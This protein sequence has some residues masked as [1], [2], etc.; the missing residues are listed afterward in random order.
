MR[1]ARWMSSAS[2]GLLEP[3]TSGLKILIHDIET[4]PEANWTWQRYK[5]NTLGNLRPDYM[6]SNVYGWHGMGEY[7]FIGQN[8]DPSYTPDNFYGKPR[9]TQDRW[10]VSRMWHLYNEADVVVAHNALKFDVPY[11][12]GRFEV[13]DLPPPRQFAIIDTLQIVKKHFRFASNSLNSLS[14]K[15]LHDAKV[16]HMGMRTWWG[17]MEGDP[18]MWKMMQEYNLQDVLLL[19]ELYDRLLPWI[20]RRKKLPTP[21]ANDWQVDGEILC[22]SPGCGGTNIKAL[23]YTPPSGAG[24]VYREWGCQSCG[25]SFTSNY[26]ERTHKPTRERIK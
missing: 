12:Q 5:T 4:A 26:A 9:P 13:Y 2:E 19:A 15:L 25:G 11:T 7:Q 8:Q 10:V 3:P 17:C 6:L 16:A 20:L 18:A 21:N 24:L 22:P 1:Q 23:G 14:E